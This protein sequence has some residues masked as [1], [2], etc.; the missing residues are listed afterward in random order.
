MRS[1]KWFEPLTSK[2]NVTTVP[3]FNHSIL[4]HS[5]IRGAADEGVLN[6]VGIGNEAAKFHFKSTKIGFSVQ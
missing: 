2:T 6:K 4:L 5:G 1:S 3:G